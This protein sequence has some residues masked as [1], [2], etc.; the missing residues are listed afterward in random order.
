MVVKS[1]YA[2]VMVREGVIFMI[3][4]ESSLTYS[5]NAGKI[6]FFFS[7]SNLSSLAFTPET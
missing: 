3:L 5:R 4:D 1:M 6:S 2:V 7:F